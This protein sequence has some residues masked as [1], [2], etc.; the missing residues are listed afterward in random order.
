M[1]ADRLEKFVNENRHKFDHVGAVRPD[2]GIYQPTVERR[3]KT[4]K[5]G[6]FRG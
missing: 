1:K 6:N 2:M 3:T 4:A 5:S